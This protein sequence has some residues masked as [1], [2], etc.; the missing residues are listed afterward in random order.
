MA[1]WC[2][3]LQNQIGGE[4]AGGGYRRHEPGVIENKTRR[5]SGRNSW[6]IWRDAGWI[7]Y[8]A[9]G[10]RSRCSGVGPHEA[11]LVPEVVVDSLETDTH[12]SSF[13]SDSPLGVDVSS[14]STHVLVVARLEVEL[15]MVSVST[16]PGSAHGCLVACGGG[17]GRHI[18]SLGGRKTDEQDTDLLASLLALLFRFA[19][20]P[21]LLLTLTEPNGSDSDTTSMT[22]RQLQTSS[23]SFFS[24]SRSSRS[25]MTLDKH[26]MVNQRRPVPQ[27]KDSHHSATSSTAS[28]GRVLFLRRYPW[29]AAT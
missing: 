29:R 11:A 22:T 18:L 26:E 28:F 15:V 8:L 2:S 9:H 5:Y 16:A 20:L 12:F 13:L 17:E 19:L 25:L 27:K 6:W 1:R 3:L 24:F 10:A 23:F 14:A 7:A 4:I 21:F